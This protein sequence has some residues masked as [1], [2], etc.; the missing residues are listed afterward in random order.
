MSEKDLVEEI[1]HT[2][3]ALNIRSINWYKFIKHFEKELMLYFRERTQTKSELATV[4]KMNRPTV[5]MKMKA[6]K[7][8]L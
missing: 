4:I 7:I 2:I 1:M 8:K 6:L 5:I 3:R